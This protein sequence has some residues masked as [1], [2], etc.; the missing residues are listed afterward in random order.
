[1]IVH[2]FMSDAEYNVLIAGGRLM[3]ATNHGSDGHRTDSVG[4]CFFIEDPDEAIHWLSGCT[5]PDWCVTMEIPDNLLRE[6]YGIYRDP[7]RDNLHAVAPRGGRP[8]VRRREY[9]LTSYSLQEVRIISAT[10][11]FSYY[12]DLRR[13]F[14]RLGILN[15]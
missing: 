9:C 11:R 8:T 3:N 2:R 1:M 5:Y 6:S 12:A 10:P 7:S 15:K 14:E 13:Y 4:F